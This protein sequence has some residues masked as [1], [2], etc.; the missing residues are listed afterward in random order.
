[1]KFSITPAKVLVVVVV[2]FIWVILILSNLEQRIEKIE[3]NFK[4]TEQGMY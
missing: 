3:E 2:A 1:M 4:Y